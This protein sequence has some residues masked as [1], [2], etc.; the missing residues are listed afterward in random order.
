MYGRV[1]CTCDQASSSTGAG[2]HSRAHHLCWA[3]HGHECLAEQMRCWWNLHE[4]RF[5]VTAARR[6]MSG[7]ARSCLPLLPSFETSLATSSARSSYVG[8]GRSE[9]LSS[10]LASCF[11]FVTERAFELMTAMHRIPST[12]ASL[13]EFIGPACRELVSSWTLMAW[14]NVIMHQ[15]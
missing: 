7:R 9:A 4:I 8:T 2:L 5:A 6:P 11:C 13:V 15:Y 10:K 14:H 3:L 12:N 1:H